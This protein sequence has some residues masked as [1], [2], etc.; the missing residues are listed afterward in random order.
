MNTEP[1]ITSIFETGH[2]GN[3]SQDEDERFSTFEH[4]CY[5]EVD[6]IGT[7]AGAASSMGATRGGPPAF[8]FDKTFWMLIASDEKI[9]FVAKV[10]NPEGG[11]D[12][13]HNVQ[14]TPQVTVPKNSTGGFDVVTVA[15]KTIGIRATLYNSKEDCDSNVNGSKLEPER[16]TSSETTPTFSQLRYYGGVEQYIKVHLKNFSDPIFYFDLTYVT[17][18]GDYEPENSQITLKKGEEYQFPYPI[19]KDE[20]DKEDFWLVLDYN[21]KTIIKLG[22]EFPTVKNIE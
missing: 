21:R 2:L 18:E 11:V 7:K 8:T 10:D 1:N 17:E 12:A 19:R 15:E 6:E 22:F 9:L 20:G 3:M 14:L 4:M 5:V 16:V 13:G